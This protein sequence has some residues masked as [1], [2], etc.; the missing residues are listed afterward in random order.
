ML[1]SERQITNTYDY[2]VYSI[3]INGSSIIEIHFHF[4]FNL[5]TEFLLF[6]AYFSYSFLPAPYSLLILLFPS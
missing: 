2:A 4:V 1:N 6:T 3:F 5:K